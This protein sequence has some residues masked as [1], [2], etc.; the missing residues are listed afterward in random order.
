[1][2]PNRKKLEEDYRKLLEFLSNECRQGMAH[3]AAYGELSRSEGCRR[4]RLEGRPDEP[5]SVNNPV[6][7]RQASPLT[8]KL[9]GELESPDLCPQGQGC[10]PETFEGR[11]PSNKSLTLA[12][13]YD[14]ALL[15]LARLVDDYK[16]AVTIF[17]FRS[18]I[19]NHPHLFDERPKFPFDEGNETIRNLRELR[20]RVYAHNDRKFAINGGTTFLNEDTMS[21]CYRSI[22]DFLE[23]AERL[24][25]R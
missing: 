14:E 18:F 2:T 23:E 19:E 12:A 10:H 25:I 3:L 22:K 13:H 1:M 24:K 16:D 21:K 17:T 6:A 8:V 9:A 7:V 4:Q 5:S 11:N 20:A 15:I